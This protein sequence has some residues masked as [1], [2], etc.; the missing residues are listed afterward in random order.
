M[1]AGVEPTRYE[2]RTAMDFVKVPSEL[3]AQ[4]LLEFAVFIETIRPIADDCECPVF[5]W[6]DDKQRNLTINLR[7]PEATP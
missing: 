6:V 1:S 4:C 2:I 3:L 7:V 5:T